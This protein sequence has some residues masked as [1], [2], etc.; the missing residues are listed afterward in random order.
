VGVV[1]DSTVFIGGERRNLTVLE[2]LGR[3]RKALGDTQVVL[4][5]M[6]AV[7]LI[8]GIWRAQTP[9]TRAHREELVE[10]IFARVPVRPVSLKT[11]RIAGEIDAKARAKGVTIPTA[12][13][14]IGATALELGFGVATANLRHFRLIPR[15]RVR[16]LE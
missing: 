11:A 6:S 16:S 10:E 9:G 15:L 12:D 1:L 3:A 8:H 2:T 7:E 5:S 14:L 4:S 13:L